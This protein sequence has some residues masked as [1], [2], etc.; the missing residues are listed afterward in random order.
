MSRHEHIF[1]ASDESIEDIAQPL[2]TAMG[3]QFTA[4]PDGELYLPVGPTVLFLG[5]HGFDDTDSPE[6]PLGRYRYMV[7]VHDRDKDYER[8]TYVARQVFDTLQAMGR[9]KIA[10]FFHDLQHLVANYDPSDRG[11]V[12]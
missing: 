7:L 9:W 10:L 1:I 12:G 8:Q 5:H 4:N 11:N 2:Q 3:G 6:V